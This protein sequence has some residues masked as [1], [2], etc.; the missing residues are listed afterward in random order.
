MENWQKRC[1]LYWSIRQMRNI[2]TVKRAQ[3]VSRPRNKRVT[4][5]NPPQWMI[6][7]RNRMAKVFSPP[8]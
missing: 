8:R 6:N 3:T 7:R 1:G 2:P 4:H 5:Y